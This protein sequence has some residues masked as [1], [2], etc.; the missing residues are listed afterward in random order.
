[1]QNEPVGAID[2]IYPDGTMDV[3]ANLTDPDGICFDKLNNL[4]V[5]RSEAGQVTKLMPDGN[6]MPIIQ[7]VAPWDCGINKFGELIV[8]LPWDGQIIKVHLSHVSDISN[9]V[10]ITLAS[11]NAP[12]LDPIGNMSVDE[13]QLLEFTITASDPDGDSLTF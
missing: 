2:I 9:I 8:S 4:F 10:S 13:D 7:D 5:G 11:N 3:L 1:V 6:S 12:I